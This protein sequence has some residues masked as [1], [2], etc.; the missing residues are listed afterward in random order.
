MLTAFVQLPE[1]IQLAILAGVTLLLGLVLAQIAKLVPWLSDFL[2]HYKDEIAVA[3]AGVI[4]TYLNSLLAAL[5]LQF[6]VAVLAAL[7][8]LLEYRR[9]RALRK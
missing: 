6:V 9:V 5:F 8:L 3:V 1:P 4:V 2:G 7:G